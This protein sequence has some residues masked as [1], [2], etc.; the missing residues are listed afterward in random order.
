MQELKLNAES[1]LKNSKDTASKENHKITYFRFNKDGDEVKNLYAFFNEQI[2]ETEKGR[3][4]VTVVQNKLNQWLAG[5]VNAG[6][7]ASNLIETIKGIKK[8][9][10]KKE[11]VKVKAAKK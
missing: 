1:F 10:V 8:G 3:I 5:F 11:S 9:S 4:S 7:T 2:I 6:Y